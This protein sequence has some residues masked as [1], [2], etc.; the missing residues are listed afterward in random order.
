MQ[1][2]GIK[3]GRRRRRMLKTN[4]Y[5]QIRVR[6]RKILCGIFKNVYGNSSENMVPQEDIFDVLLG[7][8]K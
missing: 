2:L 4:Y 5:S 8:Q 7:E 1:A 3:S 6:A